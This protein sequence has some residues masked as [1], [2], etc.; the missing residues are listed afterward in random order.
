MLVQ[1]LSFLGSLTEGRFAI[2]IAIF[3]I[4][5]Y[6]LRFWANGAK[7]D[8]ERDMHG[9]VILLTVSLYMRRLLI[10]RSNACI[11]RVF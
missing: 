9:R 4:S 7:T 5:A 10:R 11:Q 2:H 3:A 6:W 8:R 1:L